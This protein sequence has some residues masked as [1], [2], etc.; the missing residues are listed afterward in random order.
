MK[1]L[2]LVTLLSVPTVTV[3][4]AQT[5]LKKVLELK[6]PKTEDDDMPGR[7]GACVAWHPL[8]KKYYAVFAGNS[9]YPMAVFNDKGNRVSDDDQTAMIDTRGLW[10]NPATKLIA[11]NGFQD[12]GWFNYELDSKGLLSDI[13]V[14]DEGKYQPDDQSVGTYNP[15]TKKVLFLYQS[16]VYMYNSDGDR[17][18]SI[19]IHWGRKK[20]DG[21]G[22]DE[23]INEAP[24]DYNSSTVIYTGIKGQELGFLNITN[25]EIELYDIKTGFLARKL[26]L[27]STATAEAIF[28]FAYANGIYWLFNMDLRK[29]IGYK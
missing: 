26:S 13:D 17:Q 24:E 2:L 1:K 7:R 18:D 22:D 11:G 21:P 8:Q 27:P 23:D 10:Y 25:K 16:Q 9:E 3:L 29:W 12:Y 20:I 28:N 14:V 4:D 6:M 5:I 15:T 19:M